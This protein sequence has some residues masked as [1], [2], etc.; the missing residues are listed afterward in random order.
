VIGVVGSTDMRRVV[1][2]LL[3][4]FGLAILGEALMKPV[5]AHKALRGA[6]G[7]IVRNADGKPALIRDRYRE[8][9]VNWPAY[10]CCIAAGVPVTWVALLA[11][12]GILSSVRRKPNKRVSPTADGAVSSASRSLPRVGDGLP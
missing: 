7:Q 10:S 2:S 3:V 9:R 12:A 11:A 5:Y 4:A 6:G 8:F 1:L